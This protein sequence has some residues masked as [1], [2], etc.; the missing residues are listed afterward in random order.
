M[1][2]LVGNPDCCDVKAHH[3]YDQTYAKYRKIDN[4]N[5]SLSKI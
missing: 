1:S 2:D 3:F 5:V 4:Q